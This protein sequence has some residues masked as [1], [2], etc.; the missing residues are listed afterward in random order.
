MDDG[1]QAKLLYS[2]LEA[3]QRDL[4]MSLQNK[5]LPIWQ[6]LLILCSEKHKSV[7]ETV[8]F[9]KLIFKVVTLFKMELRA[10]FLPCY[11]Y[12]Y[13]FLDNL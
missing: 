8:F 11:V 9:M 13:F 2:A 1:S 6:Q 12:L 7:S 5:E 4:W 10:H 3:A